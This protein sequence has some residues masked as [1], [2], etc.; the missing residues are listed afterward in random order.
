MG[1]RLGYKLS[2]EEYK[3]VG[4][5]QTQDH[6][7]APQR[8]LWH[9]AAEAHTASEWPSHGSLHLLRQ[10]QGVGQESAGAVCA[11]VI[12]AVRARDQQVFQ[13][14]RQGLIGLAR[15]CAAHSLYH[16]WARARAS[17]TACRN[18]CVFQLVWMSANMRRR[19][20]I[21]SGRWKALQQT[22]KRILAGAGLGAGRSGQCAG[23]PWSGEV[24]QKEVNVATAADLRRAFQ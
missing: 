20:W 22:T 10:G 5:N 2:A 15:G 21:A 1:V 16:P 4:K 13:E 9:G 14:G 17:P 24:V 8:G 11:G 6:W 7:Q 12:R 23:G 19:S 18:S 3:K